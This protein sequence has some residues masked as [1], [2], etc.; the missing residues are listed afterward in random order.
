MFVFRVQSGRGCLCSESN[1][2]EGVGVPSPI[3]ERVF[4]FRPSEPAAPTVAQAKMVCES[5]YYHQRTRFSK[6]GGTTK[7]KT[8]RV[9]QSNATAHAHTQ[10]SFVI[11]RNKDWLPVLVGLTQEHS[12]S[13]RR[14]HC[15]GSF[16]DWR[17][18]GTKASWY[19]RSGPRCSLRLLPSSPSSP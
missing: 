4:V 19:R 11:I 8:A 9:N 5:G 3:R 16:V 12:C 7:T 10:T 18:I 15:I 13:I 6:K 14:P 1:P 17:C 2:G